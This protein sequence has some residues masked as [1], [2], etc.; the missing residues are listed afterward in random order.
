MQLQ[1]A[2]VAKLFVMD[3]FDLLKSLVPLLSVIG[4][5]S[6]L[7]YNRLPSL[8]FNSLHLLEM[9]VITAKSPCKPQCLP[10]P[11]VLLSTRQV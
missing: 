6:Y 5:S 7:V 8:H 11:K 2:L 1:T 3:S 10:L 4:M 9:T